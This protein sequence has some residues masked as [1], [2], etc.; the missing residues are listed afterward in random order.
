MTAKEPILSEPYALL[1]GERESVILSFFWSTAMKSPEFEWR[2]DLFKSLGYTEEEI[3]D[4]I[5]KIS[6]MDHAR[7]WCKDPNCLAPNGK[8]HD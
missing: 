2:Y 6:D 1:I 5:M 7:G 4:F 8:S 3:S